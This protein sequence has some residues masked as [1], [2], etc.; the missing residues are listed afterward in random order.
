MEGKR[1]VQLDFAPSL[2]ATLDRI[3]ERTGIGSRAEVVRQAFKFYTWLIEQWDAG[4][5]FQIEKDNEIKEVV[6]FY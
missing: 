1:R 4:Y 2:M 3:Q 6:I 5:T